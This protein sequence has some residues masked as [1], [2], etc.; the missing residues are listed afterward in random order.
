MRWLLC[1]AALAGCYRSAAAPEP[2]APRAEEEPACSPHT[3]ADDL[4]EIAMVVRAGSELVIAE[5]QHGAI[6]KMSRRGGR[7]VTIA[8]PSPE[9]GGVIGLA[10][11]EER[12]YWVREADQTLW[13]APLGGGHG[14][15]LDLP[16][17]QQIAA[18]GGALFA[19]AADGV[20]RI[21]RGQPR[22]IYENDDLHSLA[23]DGDHVYVAH[24]RDIMR[25]PAERGEAVLYAQLEHEI[26]ELVV[27][28]GTL[29]TVGHVAGTQSVST[30]PAGSKAWRHVET[31]G[32]PHSLQWTPRGLYFA[33]E[34]RLYQ[35]RGSSPRAVARLPPAADDDDPGTTPFVVDGDAL[36]VAHSAR[37]GRFA[38]RRRCHVP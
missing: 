4:E 3:Y 30:L 33:A 36:Y 35:L 24:V 25:V 16:L 32:E 9:E 13:W 2:A 15:R 20:Y 5:K 17:V 7:V 10:V 21:V 11:V 12:V 34:R 8:P 23:V 1:V 38:F 22:R 18:G 6:L 31:Q 28:D 26:G 14:R 29:F 37:G 19:I 27:R